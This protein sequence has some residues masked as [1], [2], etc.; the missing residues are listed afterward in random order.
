MRARKRCAT[1]R[2]SATRTGSRRAL[3]AADGYYEWMKLGAR[4]KQPYF[5]Q[6]ASGA[7]F[8]FGALWE[9]WRDP[10]TGE[11][12]ESCALITTPA[13]AVR[14]AHP[15]PHAVIIPARAL[16]RVAGSR[17]R[18]PRSTRSTAR[19]RRNA[20]NW[21]RAR[22]PP[23][24]QCAQRGAGPHRTASEPIRPP[25]LCRRR[26]RCSDTRAQIAAMSVAR[27]RQDLLHRLLQDGHDDAVRGAASCS[28]SARST[29]TSPAATRAP[30]T[31]RRCS[32]RSKPAI[33]GCRRSSSSTRS[34]TTRTSISGA[35]STRSFPTPDT[36]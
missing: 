35:R 20:A 16:R 4:L 7:P 17:N 33:T 6:P 34:P 14:R 11:P 1:S 29:A 31:A 27:R 9:S 18:R 12:L 30:T 5:I 28:A 8:A 15:R 26:P 36:S 22:R 10:A 21:S 13:P 32:G 2:P 3:V 25:H 23:R 19:S 24:R